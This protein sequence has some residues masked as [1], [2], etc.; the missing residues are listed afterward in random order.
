MKLG[1]CLG[2]DV[3]PQR[4]RLEVTVLE[5][6][7]I[8]VA[9]GD[10]R[11]RGTITRCTA[12]LRVGDREY[13]RSK[14]IFAKPSHRSRPPGVEPLAGM[15]HWL[16]FTQT[17]GVAG[18]RQGVNPTEPEMGANCPALAKWTKGGR[19]NRRAIVTKIGRRQYRG[20]LGIDFSSD[21]MRRLEWIVGSVQ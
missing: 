16:A 9:L 5:Q 14:L 17:D 7:R 15:Q 10:R 20:V 6:R 8:R 2:D 19:V 12:Q 4:P 18:A 21:A 13:A 11:R 3:P 1:A